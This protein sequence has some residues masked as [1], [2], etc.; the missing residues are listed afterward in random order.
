MKGFDG[1]DKGTF[2]FTGLGPGVLV[3]GSAALSLATT[4]SMHFL[5]F[6]VSVCAATDGPFVRCL[7]KGGCGKLNPTKHGGHVVTRRIGQ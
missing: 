4:A 6:R 1:A 7:P 2:T 3:V 5:H